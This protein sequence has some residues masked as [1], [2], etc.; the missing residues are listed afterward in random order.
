MT[1]LMSDV[2]LTLVALVGAILCG[3][4]AVVLFT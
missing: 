3:L 1:D 2:T 4:A